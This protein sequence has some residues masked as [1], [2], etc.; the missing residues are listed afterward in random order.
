LLVQAWGLR[1]SAEE[2]MKGFRTSPAFDTV[3]YCL[4][5]VGALIVGAL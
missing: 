2:K 3:L 4:L 5:I 1:N